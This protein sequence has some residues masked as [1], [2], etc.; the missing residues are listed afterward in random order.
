MTVKDMA[1]E[2]VVTVGPDAAARDVAL[3]MADADVGSVV[4][5]EDGQPAGI[6]TDRD[7]AMEVV[8]ENADAAALTA[9][10]LM[11]GDVSTVHEDES[12]YD[13]LAT[14]HEVGVRR[15]PLVDDEGA[16]T[17][18]VTLDDFVVLLGSELENVSGVVQSESPPY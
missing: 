4:V 9:A 18:I 15:L 8:V 16:L 14:M 13:A 6:L 3:T 11:T 5:V 1:R 2:E 17:G 10:E 7:L 12:I